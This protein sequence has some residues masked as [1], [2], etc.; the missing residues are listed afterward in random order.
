LA[1]DPD[2]LVEQDLP[3]SGLEGYLFPDTY[4]FAW[5]TPPEEIL[6]TMVGRF[7]D[8]A[9]ALRA[10][11]IDAGMSEQDMVILGSLIEK[12]T[13]AAQERAMVSAVFHNRL[14][15]G[16]LLQ[17]DPTT[18]YGHED[19]A[20]PTAADLDADTPYNTYRNPGLPP[21]PICNPGRSAL[22]A[23]LAPAAVSYLY[24]VSRNDGTHEF[25]TTLD[26][27]HRAVVRFR[28]RNRGSRGAGP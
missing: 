13:G 7:R 8:Q 21:G 20:V 3:S 24:F 12:E 19:G 23:A 16:M 14:R 6:R 17:S 2:F 18:V 10:R 25:S 5:S 22:E 15:N 28:G 26:E 11:R 9:A 4:A 27:H 1:Q